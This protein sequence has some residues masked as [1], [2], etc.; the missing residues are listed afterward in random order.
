[1]MLKGTV[2]CGFHHL[3]FCHGIRITNIS[4]KLVF[5]L[6]ML[7]SELVGKHSQG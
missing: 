4:N 7:K 1:M 3:R 2:S 6:D 5:S